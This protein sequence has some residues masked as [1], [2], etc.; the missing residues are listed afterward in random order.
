[1]SK[2]LSEYSPES[3]V[4]RN[5]VQF[6]LKEVIKEGGGGSDSFIILLELARNRSYQSPCTP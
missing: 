3:S 4:L 6:T 1:M 5:F 2:A